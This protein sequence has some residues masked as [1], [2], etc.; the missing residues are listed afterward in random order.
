M[1]IGT[2]ETLKKYI[3]VLKLLKFF[4][5]FLNNHGIHDIDFEEFLVGIT[6]AKYFFRFIV[7]LKGLLLVCFC[8]LLRNI[9]VMSLSM[10]KCQEQFFNGQKAE[11][12]IKKS[13]FGRKISN[14]FEFLVYDNP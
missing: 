13:G 3:Y 5:F 10:Y 14:F 4:D 11:I 6:Y 1:Q 12:W 2:H 9:S 8:K 7:P